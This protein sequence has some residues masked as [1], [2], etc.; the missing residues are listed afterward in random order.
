MLV[1]GMYYKFSPSQKLQLGQE[2]VE[3]S[4]LALQ[5]LHHLMPSD[6]SDLNHFFAGEPSSK[7]PAGSQESVVE[8]EREEEGEGEGEGEKEGS[9]GDVLQ[10]P[11]AK[12]SRSQVKALNIQTPQVYHTLTQSVC[13]YSVLILTET[14]KAVQ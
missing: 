11:R 5:A 13:V 12:K 2:L 1:H 14:Q 10:P 7:I 6:D 8:E 4:F 3:N 9:E